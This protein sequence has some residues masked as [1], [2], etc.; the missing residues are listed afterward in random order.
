KFRSFSGREL[1]DA[2]NRQ[3]RIDGTLADSPSVENIANSWLGRQAP[4][5]PAVTVTRNYEDGSALLEQ[6][7]RLHNAVF[8]DRKYA[9]LIF[10]TL[11]NKSVQTYED[12]NTLILNCTQHLFL[13]DPHNATQE[14]RDFVWWIPIEYLTPNNL[15]VNST[16]PVS[17]MGERTH[18]I[19]N[20]PD[21][22]SFVIMNPT[23]AG[24]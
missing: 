20:L 10:C 24:M 19:G 15:D 11:P 13:Q 1:W 23:G 6:V 7:T 16:H 17:W 22:Q 14:E 21:M 3:A 2:I 8:K 18:N 4:H 5:F 12:S 9:T